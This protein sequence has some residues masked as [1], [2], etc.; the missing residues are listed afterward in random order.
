VPDA[1]HCAQEPRQ[2]AAAPTAD[3]ELA[4]HS[5]RIAGQ[6]PTSGYRRV[7]AH[8]RREGAGAVNGKRVRRLMSELG[9]AGRP[10][11]RRCRTTSSDHP[12]PRSPN[13]VADLA[14]KEPDAVWVADSTYGR[15]QRDFVS[16]AVLMDVYW[17]STPA[18]FAAGS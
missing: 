16:L 8:L 9:L 3:R 13:L 17:M 1:R 6:W 10:A 11:Q 14:S 2:H 15:L 4:T 7:T 5:E 18:A 12:S